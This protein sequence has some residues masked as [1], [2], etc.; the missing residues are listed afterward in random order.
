M[1]L[2]DFQLLGYRE[3]HERKDTALSSYRQFRPYPM[4]TNFLKPICQPGAFKEENV[5]C[6]KLKVLI[7]TFLVWSRSIGI[8]E[9]QHLGTC[10]P[11][12]FCN[13]RSCEIGTDWDFC[14]RHSCQEHWATLTPTPLLYLVCLY[15]G[16][17]SSW[18]DILCTLISWL[19]PLLYAKVTVLDK[20]ASPETSLGKVSRRQWGMARGSSLDTCSIKTVPQGTGPGQECQNHC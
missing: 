9:K 13:S 2:P 14:F 16:F 3:W 6:P 15:S 11:L 4:S 8:K 1:Q 7:Q 5:I 20:S 12:R 18:E 19:I 17:L 10:W